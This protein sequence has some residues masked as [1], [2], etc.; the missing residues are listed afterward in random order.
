MIYFRHY[1]SP[2]GRLTLVSNGPALTGL[3]FGGQAFLLDGQRE[4]GQGRERPAG[5]PYEHYCEGEEKC[6][7]N[8]VLPVFADTCRW[9]D[10]YFSGRDPGFLPQLAPEGTAFRREVWDLLLRIPYGSTVSYGA[11][12]AIVAER[13]AV[14]CISGTRVDSRLGGTLRDFEAYRADGTHQADGALQVDGAL[15]AGGK[16]RAGG[17]H[18]ADGALPTGGTQRVGGIGKMSA[19]A[20]GGAVGHNPIPIIIPCHRVIAADGSIGGFSCGLERKIQLL[21]LEG[22]IFRSSRW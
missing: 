12:A 4:P 18:Q 16:L 5:G 21:K 1:D 3:K 19:Q 14:N 7:G 15:R 17:A 20:I 13:R 9:L 8:A 10:I 22:I 2:L 6:Y 11:L